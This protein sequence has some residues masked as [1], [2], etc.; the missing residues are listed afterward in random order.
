MTGLC[1]RSVVAQITGQHVLLEILWKYVGEGV[2]HNS[3]KWAIDFKMCE[4]ELQMDLTANVS[5]QGPKVLT[6]WKGDDTICKNWVHTEMTDCSRR[7]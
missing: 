2:K 3:N 7:L 5:S 4:R 6:T 1:C